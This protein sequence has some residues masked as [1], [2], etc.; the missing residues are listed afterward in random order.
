MQDLQKKVYSIDSG[1]SAVVLSDIGSC[2]IEGNNK[3]GF[4]V[5]FK[6]H[7]RVHILN[8]SGYHHGDVHKLLVFRA[9]RA[10]SRGA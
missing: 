8:K 6:H 7:K 10:A 3:G 4:S 1:A 5:V 2:R 9:K